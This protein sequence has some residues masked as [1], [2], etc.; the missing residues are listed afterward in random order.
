MPNTNT[1]QVNKKFQKLSKGNFIQNAAYLR[2][3]FF[4]TGTTTEDTVERFGS[5]DHARDEART[6]TSRII[7]HTRRSNYRIAGYI[8]E[9]LD[10]F[11][12]N[13]KGRAR[14]IFEQTPPE[15]LRVVLKSLTI[16]EKRTGQPIGRILS[17]RPDIER[18]EQG[19]FVKKVVLVDN[20]KKITR[21]YKGN[22]YND[23]F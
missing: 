4:L 22:D 8:K 13:K 15:V 3:R 21:I 18:D 20:P 11:A 1:N 5:Y 14:E 16:Y 12:N 17:I 10:L 19:Y 23:A 6:A 7:K 2:A 9:V